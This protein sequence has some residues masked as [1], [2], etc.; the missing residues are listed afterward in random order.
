M[1]RRVS[2]ERSQVPAGKSGSTFVVIKTCRERSEYLKETSLR[3]ELNII[4]IKVRFHLH[5]LEKFF[6]CLPRA[7]NT[8]QGDKY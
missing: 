6:L 3:L 2:H 5:S 4:K 8:C 1:T 7:Q